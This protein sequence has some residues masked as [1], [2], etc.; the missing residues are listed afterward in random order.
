MDECKG[1][2]TSDILNDCDNSSVAGLEINVLIFNSEDIDRTAVTYD[3]NNKVIMDGFAL[4][5]TKT[6]FL[7]QGV[8]QVQSTAWELVK[9]ET[10]LD[11][12][13]HIF[14]G[15]V[16]S[17]SAENK[18]Q[19][20]QMSEGGSYVVIVEKKWKGQDNDDAF[21]IYGISSGLEL[22]VATYNSNENDGSALIELS[23]PDGFEEPRIPA[24]V[25]IG[26][27]AATKALFDNKF[28]A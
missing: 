12:K 10:S 17:L 9:K 6:G 3:V 26:D 18:L 4:K 27:Y 14:N 1:F 21:D 19:L 24:N 2:M 5:A 15:Y 20:E 7:I 23:S 13:K 11:K 25:L 16:L 22:N 8:K 28:A